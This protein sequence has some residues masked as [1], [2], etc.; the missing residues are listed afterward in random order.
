M[1]GVYNVHERLLAGRA[2]WGADRRPVER[3]RH[4][5][6]TGSGR[7]WSSTAHSDRGGRQARPGPLHRRRVRPLHL[8]ALHLQR[9]TRLHG[10]HEYVYNNRRG[11]HAA[12]TLAMDAAAAPASPG[13]SCGSRSATPA[14]RTTSAAPNFGLH[15]RSGAPGALGPV[16]PAAARPRA[17]I[18][19]Q[20]PPPSHPEHPAREVASDFS[21]RRT[22]AADIARPLLQVRLP[23]GSNAREPRP[24]RAPA[25]L[26]QAGSVVVTTARRALRMWEPPRRRTWARAQAVSAVSPLRT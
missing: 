11:T 2:T 22:T 25:R 5:G 26:R 21:R 8:G 13:R 15:G 19:R 24:G 20:P 3:R 18:P 23:G 17:L 7:R 14:W 9:A 1:E 10:F 6:H 4:A 12:A 16:R